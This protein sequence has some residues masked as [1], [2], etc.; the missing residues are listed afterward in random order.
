MLMLGA[1]D[2]RCGKTTLAIELLRSVRGG[3]ALAGVKVTTVHDRH[4]APCPRG[5][6]GCGVCD[7]LVGPYELR[8]ET[9]GAPGKDTTRL[10][11]AGARPVLWLCSRP[12]E[13]LEAGALELSTRIGSD[14]ASVCESNSLR[15]VAE[16]DLFVVVR[17]HDTELVKRSCREVLPLADA[18]VDHDG[19]SFTPGSSTFRLEGGRWTYRRPV[20]AVVLAGGRSTRM[21]RDK[22]LLPVSGR[23]MIEHIVDQLR[24]HVDEI[25]VSADDSSKYAFLG[26][27]VVP[28]REPGLGPMMAIASTLERASHEACLVV[29]CDVPRLPGRLLRRLLREARGEADVAVP[30][31]AEGHYEPLFAIYRKSAAPA[32]DLALAGGARRIASVYGEL[33]TTKLDLAPG[34]ELINI[35]T[36]EEYGAEVGEER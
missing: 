24:P 9:G 26:L 29:P 36:V 5:N 21:G 30:V 15:R 34:Q 23:T 3:R 32:L 17:R 2:R 28:D 10:Y 25:L 19:E 31:T 22:A 7:S 1:A 16:P 11:E 18:V 14:S 8:E 12:G 6:D 35:N 4:G 20:T 33:R 27:D 13:A